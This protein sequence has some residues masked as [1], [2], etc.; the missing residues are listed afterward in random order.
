[1]DKHAPMFTIDKNPKEDK[2]LFDWDL[3]HEIKIIRKWK[4]ENISKSLVSCKY[5]SHL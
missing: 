2:L 3:S 4:Y 1:M 5:E